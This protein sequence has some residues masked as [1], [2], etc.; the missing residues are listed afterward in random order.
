MR[1]MLMSFASYNLWLPGSFTGQHLARLFV[2][3]EP[4]IHWP[5]GANAV[6][7]HRPQCPAHLRPVKQALELDP[8]GNLSP[9]GYLCWASAAGLAL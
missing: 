5:A 9:A 4:G 1:A 2:D 7:Q 6:W 8:R 3:Y